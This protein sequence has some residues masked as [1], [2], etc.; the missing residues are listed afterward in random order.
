MIK[1]IIF[2]IDGTLADNTS[3][4]IIDALNFSLKKFGLKK[5]L[6]LREFKKVRK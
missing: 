6:I 4:D 5:K 1:N 2:D 3:E